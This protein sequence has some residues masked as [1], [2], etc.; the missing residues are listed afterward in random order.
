VRPWLLAV[1]IA[2][3]AVALTAAA[4]SGVIDPAA[5]MATDGSLR[6]GQLWRLITGPMVHA[7]WGHLVRDLALLLAVAIAF[8]DSLGRR[9]FAVLCLA[10]LAVPTAAVFVFEPDI[11]IYYGTSG[12]T[13][14]LLAAAAVG[15]L[16]RPDGTQM[17][18]LLGA[19]VAV[20]LIAK[21]AF[22]LAS[23][24]PAFPMD[25]GPGVR[26]LPS[27]HAAGA[28]VGFLLSMVAAQSAR[29]ASPARARGGA[30]V[31]SVLAVRAAGSGSAG[32]VEGSAFAGG[33]ARRRFGLRARWP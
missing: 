29:A 6:A 23:G 28:I 26:Q 33:A 17:T 19:G 5:V 1:L 27:A 2:V 25:L 31:A 20:G 11:A 32:S 13:H 4:R 9:R 7:T 22:E 16:R 18:R 30:G 8:G 10:G 14:A 21:L 15:E 24:A 12:L 3:A